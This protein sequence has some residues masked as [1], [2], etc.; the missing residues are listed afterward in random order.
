MGT[1]YN[2]IG[3]VQ[4]AR[5]DYEAALVAFHRAKLLLKQAGNRSDLAS[6]Y[7]N[8]G[9]IYYARGE[10]DAALAMF[11]KAAPVLEKIGDRAMLATVTNNIGGVEPGDD[12]FTSP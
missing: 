8:I 6:L 11:Q 9:G 1:A 3:M 5:G 2:N 7:N 4:Q 10:Y 12:P